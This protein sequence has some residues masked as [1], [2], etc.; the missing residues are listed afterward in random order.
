MPVLPINERGK[1]SLED[2][3]LTFKRFVALKLFESVSKVTSCRY[4][5]V[6]K[7]NSDIDGCPCRHSIHSRSYLR[8]Y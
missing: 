1:I 6:A 4:M 3:Q 5:I 2:F 7:V 8:K